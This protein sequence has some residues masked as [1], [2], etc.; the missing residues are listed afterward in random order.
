MA[1]PLIDLSG[2]S[3]PERAE[4]AAVTRQ[5][6]AELPARPEPLDTGLRARFEAAADYLEDH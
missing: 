6:L 3:D 5:L 4:L 1:E 2:L